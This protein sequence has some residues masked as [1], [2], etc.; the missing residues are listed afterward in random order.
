MP[1]FTIK[2]PHDKPA[3]CPF[4][5]GRTL[6]PR[7]GRSYSLA[8]ATSQVSQ[9]EEGIS[10]GI[11]YTLPRSSRS[12]LPDNIDVFPGA[13]RLAN[14]FRL[15]EYCQIAAAQA[16]EATICAAPN[17]L[18]DLPG[19]DQLPPLTWVPQTFTHKCECINLGQ[20]NPCS[21]NYLAF[22]DTHYEAGGPI[23][24]PGSDICF[25]TR[26]PLRDF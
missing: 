6:L 13:K 12:Q 18:S 4:T 14:L 3:S 19:A 16:C 20:E 17:L 10:G 23:Y 22:A 11:T 1:S 8:S 25:T 26:K 5:P 15:N 24:T 2:D 7:P 21:P 9:E